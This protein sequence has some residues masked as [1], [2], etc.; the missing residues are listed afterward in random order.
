MALLAGHTGDVLLF[1]NY[2]DDLSSPL[3]TI[4]EVAGLL[5]ISPSGVRRLQQQRRIPFLKV[6]GGVRFLKED[7]RSYLSAQRVEV[8]NY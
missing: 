4:S 2:I 6:G 8:I 5:K 7:I 1:D 3:L